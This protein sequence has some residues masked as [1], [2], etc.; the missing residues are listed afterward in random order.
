MYAQSNYVDTINLY[1]NVVG[2]AGS[3][4]YTSNSHYISN[5]QHK[6]IYFH[7]STPLYANEQYREYG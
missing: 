7:T 6:S 4:T 1:A 2:L 3:Y 5:L